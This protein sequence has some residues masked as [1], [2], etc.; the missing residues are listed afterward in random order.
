[1]LKAEHPEFRIVGKVLDGNPVITLYFQGGR[2]QGG[3]DSGIDTVF[4]YPVHFE[5]RDV[6]AHGKKLEELTK[7]VANDR[8]YPD[9]AALVTI[10]GD[11]DL[12]RFLSESR[13]T[14]DRLYLALPFLMT[15]RG[16]PVI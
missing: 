10:L 12:P 14:V 15:A 2:E 6:F 13:A 16:T 11:H 4:D 5:L 1:M 3:I 7:L 8:L 9:P